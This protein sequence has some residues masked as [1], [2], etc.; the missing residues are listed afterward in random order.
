MSIG[1]GRSFALRE[2][3]KSRLAILEAEEKRAIPFD[4]SPAKPALIVDRRRSIHPDEP[5][6][7]GLLPEGVDRGRIATQMIGAIEAAP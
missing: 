4:R 2:N 6:G 5:A 3:R 1:G 7:I